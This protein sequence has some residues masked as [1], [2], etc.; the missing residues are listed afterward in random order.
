MASSACAFGGSLALAMR[1]P[2]RHFAEPQDNGAPSTTHAK[3]WRVRLAR[4]TDRQVIVLFADQACDALA[5]SRKRPPIVKP[6]TAEHFS[7]ASTHRGSE[8]GAD[9]LHFR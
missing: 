9:P 6:V 5:R 1:S 4:L 7:T 8:I 3:S 2:R